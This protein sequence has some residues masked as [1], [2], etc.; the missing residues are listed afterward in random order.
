MTV[1]LLLDQSG[2][3]V[4]D[5]ASNDHTYDNAPIPR[6][7]AGGGRR[8]RCARCASCHRPGRPGSSTLYHEVGFDVALHEPFANTDVPGAVRV[9]TGPLQKVAAG[10]G[11]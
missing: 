4:I 1:D 10:L 8:D 5:A 2:L 6:E 7:R 9:D 3:V 11:A